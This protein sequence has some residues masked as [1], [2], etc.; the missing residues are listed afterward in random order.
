[1]TFNQ[2]TFARRDPGEVHLDKVLDGPALR[3]QPPEERV[4]PGTQ[5][6]DLHRGVAGLVI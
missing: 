5:V 6:Q 1:M 4:E 2:V 3:H